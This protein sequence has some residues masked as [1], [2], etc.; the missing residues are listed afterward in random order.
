MIISS[1]A[2]QSLEQRTHK[3]TELVAFIE[4]ALEEEI[5]FLT[6]SILY[7]STCLNDLGEDF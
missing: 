2:T 6:P 4:E 3:T 1:S 5:Y 7:V